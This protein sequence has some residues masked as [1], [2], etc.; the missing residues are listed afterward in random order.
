MA[1]CDISPISGFQSTNLNNRI[2]SFSRLGDRVLRTLGYPFINVEVHKDQLHENISIAVEY[3]TKFAGYTKEYLIF[4]SAMYKKD[5]GI[6]LD[7]LFSFQNRDQNLHLKKCNYTLLFFPVST[8]SLHWKQ[9]EMKP[10]VRL[11][12]HV[13]GYPRATVHSFLVSQNYRDLARAFEL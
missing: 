11:Q 10:Q 9:H 4:D 5:Y 13:E 6:K 3:F 7:E 8:I 2:D 12:F 1:N